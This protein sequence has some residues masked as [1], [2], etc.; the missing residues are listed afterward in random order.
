AWMQCWGN[1]TVHAHKIAY[2]YYEKHPALAIPNAFGVPEPPV[3]VHW[4][5]DFAR[6][7][8]VPRAYDFGPERISWM[9]HLLTNWMGDDGFL[10]RLNCQ[11]RHHNLVGDTTWCKG[12]VTGKRIEGDEAIVDCEIWAE[13]QDGTLTVKGTAEVVLP[14]RG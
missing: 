1:W 7:V 11:I 10:R 3:R 6:E 8:G 2:K 4:D 13:N 5:H 9:G 14:R 12:R